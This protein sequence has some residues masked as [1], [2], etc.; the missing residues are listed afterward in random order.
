V[1]PVTNIDQLVLVLRRRLLERSRTEKTSLGRQQSPGRQAS[2]LESVYAL[3]RIEG[4][5]DRQ[6][7]RGLIQSILTEQF[8]SAL[9]N[10][11]KF[12]QIVERVVD[13][14][15][16]DPAASKLLAVIVQELRDA[17]R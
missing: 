4:V 10:E 11:A 12:Q 6:L 3:A 17:A 13:T 9:I 7:R 15:D 16:E 2:G 1:D 8:G 14:M 5:D